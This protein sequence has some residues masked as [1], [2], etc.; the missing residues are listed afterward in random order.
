MYTL[1][2]Y[3][4]NPASRIVRF[5]T[6]EAVQASMTEYLQ[7]QVQAFNVDCEEV[8]FDGKYKPDQGEMLVIEEFDDIDSLAAVVASPLDCPVADPAELSFDQIR[9]LFFGVQEEDGSWSVYVQGFDR[10]RLISSAGFSI[11][12]SVDTYKK[13]EGTGLTLDNKIAA[14]LRGSKLSF[15]SFFQVRQIFD[16]TSYFQEATENDIKEFAALQQLKV[17]SAE[18]L[19]AASDT[20]VRRKVWL[21]L[22]S[23][24]L[25]KVPLNDIKAI[26]AE[27]NIALDYVAVDGEE[28]IQIP[29][30]KKA[31]KNLLRFLD[32]DYYKS[33]LSKT[34]FLS[35]SKRAV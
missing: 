11:F 34:N 33:P 12:H 3:T 5:A 14:R 9:A 10:R 17:E 19:M 23:G 7:R 22:Q 18:E 20:W 28:R 27:F 35:N 8:V 1:F 30:G 16:M 24:I 21:V 31:L 29:T 2:G 26:A 15:F 6:S 25:Q 4:R 13:I 32:E